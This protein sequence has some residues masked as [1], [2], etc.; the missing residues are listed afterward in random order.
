MRNCGCFSLGTGTRLRVFSEQII[1][2]PW[3][4]GLLVSIKHR[5]R[6]SGG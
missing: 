3:M 2:K 6:G 1:F 4:E 5:A